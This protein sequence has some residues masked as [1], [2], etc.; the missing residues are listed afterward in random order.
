MKLPTSHVFLTPSKVERIW[1]VLDAAN[2]RLNDDLTILMG[3]VRDPEAKAALQRVMK[4]REDLQRFV[5]SILA[6]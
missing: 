4:T 3:L 6:V 5:A 2:L 1:A